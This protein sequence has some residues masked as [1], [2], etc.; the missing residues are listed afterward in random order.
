MARQTDTD[1]NHHIPSLQIDTAAIAARMAAL[2]ETEPCPHCGLP[3]TQMAVDV[4][5]LLAEV[6]RLYAVLLTTRCHAA[7]RLAAIRA[8][9]GAASDGEADPLEYLRDELAE[10]SSVTIPG[11]VRGWWR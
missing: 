3:L 8:T 1:T 2:A 5:D 6:V 7:N 9:L 4:S 11:Q 10:S